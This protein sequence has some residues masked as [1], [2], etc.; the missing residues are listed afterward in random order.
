MKKL[1][2]Q[3]NMRHIMKKI[4]N[5]CAFSTAKHL[6]V[7]YRDVNEGA[8]SRLIMQHSPTAT[9][10]TAATSTSTTASTSAGHRHLGIHVEWVT[11]AGD[12]DA[13][14]VHRQRGTRS[15][16]LTSSRG[17]VTA[18]CHT[19]GSLAVGR[20]VGANTSTGAIVS[21]TTTTAAD[22]ATIITRLYCCCRCCFLLQY[23]LPQ[24]IRLC[25]GAADASSVHR[26]IHRVP[27]VCKRLLQ[28]AEPPLPLPLQLVAHVPGVD[29]AHQG[30]GEVLHEQGG[31]EGAVPGLP[32]RLLGAHQLAC[33]VLLAVEDVPLLER[34]HRGARGGDV[35]TRG[36]G[37][38]ELCGIWMRG[39]QHGGDVWQNI[40]HV[41]H[42]F[43]V[44]FGA[45]AVLGYH[46]RYQYALAVSG[47]D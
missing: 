12:G 14:I 44:G 9:T 2:Y 30:R 1:N 4:T 32:R 8:G 10:A 33:V 18:Q 28:R 38:G 29:T 45:R 23:L 41:I 3:Q 34:V 27:P 25:P 22:G 47:A 31:D 24:S 11:A 20:V 43:D 19:H 17:R 13:H 39:R 15:P 7:L 5:K 6:R 36:G 42:Y 16:C 21:T 46:V 26:D 40:W 35:E 37:G